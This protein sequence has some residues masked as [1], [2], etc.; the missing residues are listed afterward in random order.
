MPSVPLC[1]NVMGVRKY[2]PCYLS[3]IGLFSMKVT[4]QN[5]HI[6]QPLLLHF[7][8]VLFLNYQQTPGEQFGSSFHCVSCLT[9]VQIPTD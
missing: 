2:F 3:L 8:Q 4:R 1:C 6:T 9:M 5:Y 7:T